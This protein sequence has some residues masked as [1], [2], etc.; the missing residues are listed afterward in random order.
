MAR[1]DRYYIKRFEDETNLRCYLLVD[2]SRSMSYGSLAWTK[3]DYA[4][5]AAATLAYFLASQRDAVGLVTF[6]QQIAEYLPARHRPGH[7]RRLMLAL[8]RP[9]GGSATDLAA[10]LEQVARTV[11]KRGLVVLI[12]DLLAP[13]E[14]LQTQLGYLRSRGHEVV[15]LRMLDPAEL[16]FQL[17]EPALFLDLESGRELYIDPAVARRDYQARFQAH[18]EAIGTICRDLG[19]EYSRLPTDR[20]LELALFDFVRLR[21]HG[22]ESGLRGPQPPRTE[23]AMS[24]LTPLYIAGLLAV[25]LPIIFHLIRRTPRGQVPF[26][27]LMFLSPSPPRLTRRSRLNNIFLLILRGLALSLLAF[28]F[29]RPFLRDAANLE[30]SDKPSR[31]IAI[32]VDTSASMR[33]GD[34]WRQATEKTEQAL[35]TVTPA[36]QVALLAFSD[37]VRTL[38]RFEDWNKLDPLQRNGFVNG[39]IRELKPTWGATE[40][41]QALVAAADLLAD[42]SEA[43]DSSTVSAGRSFW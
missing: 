20:P 29:A 25:S 7:L 42:A 5:T 6:D 39:Q 24:F 13:I 19:I 10:P 30:T 37:A 43:K 11:R 9:T 32:L 36:D 23:A 8:E 15:V 17:A 41:G 22:G 2:L 21:T 3:A 38:V 26:S 31:R 18:D 14:T 34:L 33:R 27:S 28:A 4:R 12:S 16:E 40:L 1:T 35:A